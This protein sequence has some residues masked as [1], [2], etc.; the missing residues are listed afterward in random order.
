M[1]VRTNYIHIRGF[2]LFLLLSIG[3]C[4]SEQP[5]ATSAVEPGRAIA[6]P[7]GAE[8]TQLHYSPY[9]SG[10]DPGQPYPLSRGQYL[11][12]EPGVRSVYFG[13]THV[14]TSYSADAAFMGATLG[15]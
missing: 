7:A 2:L 8:Q 9:A 11:G 1:I 6:A 10:G 15:P 4:N 5:P 12:G 14:H 3:A 13:D